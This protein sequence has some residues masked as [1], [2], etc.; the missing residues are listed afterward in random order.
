[1]QA[2]RKIHYKWIVVCSCFLMVFTC[3]GF[4]SSTTPLFLGPITETLGIKRSL[5]SVS[6]SLRYITTAIVNV[7]FGALIA[8][9]GARKLICFGFLALIG[10][11]LCYGLATHIAVLYL[12]GI[13]LGM[14]FSF[15]TTTMVG[16]IVHKWCKKNKGTI[17]GAVLA[18]NG[19]GGA[20]S[21]QIV[22]PIIE[23]SKGYRAAYLVIAAILAAVGMLVVLLVREAPK[24]GEEE[25]GDNAASP[26][27]RRGR[28]WVG[29]ESGV[30]FRR[31]YTWAVLV[32]IFLCGLTL[33]GITGISA[34][35]MRD[36]GLDPAFVATVISVHSLAL[37]G[38]KFL[39]G[40]LYD[41]FGLRVTVAISTLTGVGVMIA[42]ASVTDTVL[43]AVLAVIY[44]VFSALA[45]P[46]ETVMLPIFANDLFGEHSYNKMLGIIVSVNTAG[47]AAG[48]L[49]MNICFDLLKSYRSA[50]FVSAGLMA[51]VA[52]SIQVAFTGAYRQKRA[53]LAAVEQGNE[54]NKI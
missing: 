22:S 25:E 42:L 29:V 13:L 9:I 24:N 6:S 52:I 14:G 47:Y 20:L 18:A 38:F 46:L 53:I 44:G 30:A 54:A 28:G 12:G 19:L 50:L 48:A 15:T 35:H 10:S 5:F 17:M 45:L 4:C 41:R 16:F 8:R 23:S 37:A 21:V 26:K 31:P 34:A 36:V 7:F 11:A 49:F 2:K 40:F 3:L 27:K 33:N 32:C 51:I 1:M 43:G 39:S